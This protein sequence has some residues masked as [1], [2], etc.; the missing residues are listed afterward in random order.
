MLFEG[1]THGA[2]LAGR[3][4]QILAGTPVD[5]LLPMRSPNRL[6]FDGRE[7]ARFGIDETSIPPDAN[8]INR[9]VSLWTGNRKAILITGVVLL[10]Q[11]FLIAGLLFQGRRRRSAERAL[12][13]RQDELYRSQSRYTLATAAGSVGVWDWNFETNELFVDSGLKAILGFAADE[14]SNRPEDWGSRVDPRDL[15]VA[16]AAVQACA[17]GASDTYEVEHRM[18]H[19]DGSVKWM[20]SRGSALRAAN[21]T[22]LRLVGTKVDI[23]Q[24]KVA[25]VAVRE[26]Q[27]ILDESHREV[28]D[29]AGRLITSQEVERARLARDL[30]DDLSQE[31]AGLSI[32]LSGLK[33]RLAGNR[34]PGDVQGA[35]SSIQERTM[36]LADSIRRLSHDLHPTVLE[37]AGLVAALQAHCADLHRQQ[38]VKVIFAAQGDFESVSADAALC[39]YRVA[40]ESLR[41]VVTHANAARADVFL[42]RIGDD[43]ELSISDDGGGF[44]IGRTRRQ[45]DGLGLISIAERVRL[46][47]GTVSIVTELGKGTR[48]RVQV[49]ANGH[50][51]AAPSV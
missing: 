20:L 24:R 29:L 37:H 32:A 36:G 40:Q 4:L 43:A 48:V 17:D 35:V 7:L 12:R 25:E 2:D 30:H 19:K 33:R 11:S 14:I 23:T 26:G 21:G 9:Q 27:A 42:E 13:D 10:G 3:A 18:L 41:N 15:P 44:E 47:G 1:T 45:S 31:I 49:P 16:A 50:V 28:Q 22:L 39:L 8:V 34:D 46:V 38:P 6:S 5:K 51:L